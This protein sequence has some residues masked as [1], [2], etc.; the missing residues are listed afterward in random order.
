MFFS[1]NKLWMAKKTKNSL[2][3]S[4]ECKMCVCVST[5]LRFTPSLSH[6]TTPALFTNFVAA[7]AHT[8]R[9]RVDLSLSLSNSVSLSL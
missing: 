4:D 3:P 9:A 6:F 5:T 2:R 8:G 1:N 7:C